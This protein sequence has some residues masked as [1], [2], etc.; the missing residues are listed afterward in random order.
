MKTT[1]VRLSAACVALTL[2]ALTMIY[3]VPAH[4]Y[5]LLGGGVGWKVQRR[6]MGGFAGLNSDQYQ[7]CAWGE[8]GRKYSL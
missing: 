2:V 4:S 1:G 6:Q 5:L 8:A 7:H 3:V